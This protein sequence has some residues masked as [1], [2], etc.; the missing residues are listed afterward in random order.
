MSLSITANRIWALFMIV[1][2]TTTSILVLR[3]MGLYDDFDSSMAETFSSMTPAG[4]IGSPFLFSAN[5][6]EDMG[7]LAKGGK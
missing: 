4:L 6:T 2:I 7:R 5:P 3:M 1:L